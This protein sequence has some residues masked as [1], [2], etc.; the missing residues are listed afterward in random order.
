MR[1][2]CS[3]RSS[4]ST[5]VRRPYSQPSS[6]IRVA[7]LNPPIVGYNVVALTHTLSGKLPN[8]LTSPIPSTFKGPAHLRILTRC[9]LVL[10]SASQN[11]RLST[12]T[13]AY[14]V[15]ALR[16]TTQKTL[17][18]SCRELDCDLISLDLTQRYD[19][20]FKGKTLMQ[21]VDRG[22]LLELCYSPAVMAS[23]PVVRRTVIGNA[24]ALIRATKGR[25]L[26]VSSGVTRVAGCRGPADVV[27]M[28]AV[29]G[30]GPEKGKEAMTEGPRRVV[31][32]AALK[33]ESFRGVVRVVH[34]GEKREQ[35]QQQQVGKGNGASAADGAT[36]NSQKRKASA[37]E[38]GVADGSETVAKPLS[39]RELKRRK[40]AEE[41]A[42]RDARMSDI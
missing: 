7:L 32:T 6:P 26:V 8:D 28:T 25:G 23:D 38:P 39:K 9:N 36:S 3:A 17:E 18:Q 19:F 21:A 35:E 29:W 10:D 33:R 15:L 13:S 1:Q 2:T 41:Q 20:F 22:V 37:V 12:L 30:L 31:A 40:K 27:N 5:S 16:P 11:H 34:G 4:S 42:K 14:D 24:T